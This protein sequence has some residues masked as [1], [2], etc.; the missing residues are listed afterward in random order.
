M[1]I[2]VAMVRCCYGNKVA[3]VTDIAIVTDVAMIMTDVAM[4]MTDSCYGNDSLALCPGL[5]S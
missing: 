2:I 1:V 5:F 4:I 3:M